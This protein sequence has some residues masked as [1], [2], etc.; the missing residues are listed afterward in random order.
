MELKKLQNENNSI[1]M[2]MVTDFLN[3]YCCR[4]EDEKFVLYKL[5]LPENIMSL[6][7]YNELTRVTHVISNVEIDAIT[8]YFNGHYNTFRFTCKGNPIDE[9]AIV[10]KQ[11]DGYLYRGDGQYQIMD[12]NGLI[13]FK[14]VIRTLSENND[15]LNKFSKYVEV[16]HYG[17]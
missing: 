15:I 12:K 5:E 7:N 9:N 3:M 17:R 8:P 14:K 2:E 4:E 13:D 1:P 11:Y 10:M 6:N 16:L